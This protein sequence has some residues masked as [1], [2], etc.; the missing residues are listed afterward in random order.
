[1]REVFT[2]ENLHDSASLAKPARL[3]VLGHPVA[4]S[5][6]PELHQPALDAL[7]IDASYIRM[8]IEPGDIGRAFEM[9]RAAGFIGCNVTVPHKQEAMACCT[10]I[11]PQAGQLGAV[12]TVLFRDGETLGH[13]T[14]GPGFVAAIREVFGIGCAEVHTLVLGAGGG[15]GQAIATQ[16]C[17]EKPR[18]LTLVN[19]SLPKIRD[20]AGRLR[21]ISPETAV[22]TLALDD[23][24]LEA[25]CH[26]AELLVQ[27]T[28]L[29]LRKS[30]PP[31]VPATC[32]LPGHRVY[33]TI[34]QPPETAFLAAARN[35]G[36]RTGNG[37]SL[38]IHQGALA[39]QYWFPGTSPLPHMRMDPD[40]KPAG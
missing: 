22:T 39:F 35:A 34:Y 12:N 13:N 18:R 15:A 37:L 33:D 7:G 27:T 32:F 6:S 25:R 20:L 36:C 31:V 26:G 8:D 16:C 30:D 9:M 3:A 38:L 5:A 23:P 40:R 19:R 24:E 11:T 4:H 14:D 1:M 17:L 10:G 21:E 28:S 2:L 29:G